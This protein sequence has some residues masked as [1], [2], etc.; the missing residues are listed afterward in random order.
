MMENRKGK[1]TLKDVAK[2]LGISTSTVSKALND[3]HEISPNTKAK[4]K[5]FAVKVGYSPDSIA[6]SL[7]RGKSQIIGII[8]CSVD[9]IFT[10]QMLDSIQHTCN[11]NGYSTLIMPSDESY[12]IE[13]KHT[14]LLLSRGVDGLLISPAST[15]SSIDHLEKVRLNNIPLVL[16]DRLLDDLNVSKVGTKNAEGAYMATDHLIKNGFKKI[17]LLHADTA[18]N[19]HKKRFEGYGQALADHGIAIHDDYI[20]YC[21][22]RNRETLK[23]S[24]GKAL[25][26]LMN[27]ATPPDAIF[28]ATDQITLQSLR[29]IR[30]MG[31]SIPEDLALIGFSNTELADDLNPAL[32]TVIQPSRELA[33]IAANLLFEHIKLKNNQQEPVPETILLDTQLIARASTKKKD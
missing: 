1:F 4:V 8:V 20:K 14:E 30:N 3:S 25:E 2:A 15:T 13:K 9:N 19:I 16:F 33:A 10:A 29:G 12:E 22:V 7:K 23:N 26:E 28:A 31:L 6:Q 17:A 5:A 11:K 24:I 21:D 18:L 32:S 27:L